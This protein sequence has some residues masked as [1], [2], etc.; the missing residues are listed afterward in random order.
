MSAYT[1]PPIVRNLRHQLWLRKVARE[2]WALQLTKWLDCSE[3]RAWELLRG[4]PPSLEEMRKLAEQT[5]LTEEQLQSSEQGGQPSILAE[6]LSYLLDA[7]KR[8]GK[9]VLAA[10][11]GV[12]QGTISRW[13]AGGRPESRYQEAIKEYFGL[14]S[15][16]DLETFPLFLELSPVGSR[17]QREWL[18]RHVD[19]LD[20]ET[21]RLLF[22]ALEKLLR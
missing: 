3:W 2:Q 11:L 10:E 22:P 12:Q 19:E 21:L 16:V 1:L 8:G 18:H 15:T 4:V 9:K 20:T 17:E 13:M 6:N 7:P 5:G 14:P